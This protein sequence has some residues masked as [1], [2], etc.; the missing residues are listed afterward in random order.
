MFK[1]W[2]K[3]EKDL[4]AIENLI[5]KHKRCL[6]VG[7]VG[8]GKTFIS[9]QYAINNP[10]KRFTFIVPNSKT[11]DFFDDF[12]AISNLGEIKKSKV[13]KRVNV[14]NYWEKI[15]PY[16]TKVAI[17]KNKVFKC[18]VDF[19]TL[20]TAKGILKGV[21]RSFEKKAFKIPK[22][23]GITIKKVITTE[24]TGEV[25]REKNTL[26]GKN[27]E[28][29]CNIIDTTRD[30]QWLAHSHIN[31]IT[32]T[33]YTNLPLKLL[34]GRNLVV[35]ETHIIFNNNK[36]SYQI[37]DWDTLLCMTATV[38]SNHL[39]NL[40]KM[41]DVFQITNTRTRQSYIDKYYN[42]YKIKGLN[43]KHDI[44]I[45]TDLKVPASKVIA[46]IEPYMYTRLG[47]A[48]EKW[49]ETI[50]TNKYKLSQ[51]TIA[52]INNIVNAG[53]QY[54]TEDGKPDFRKELYTIR[55]EN[56]I[57]EI[58]T[59][60]WFLVVNSKITETMMI[61]QLLSGVIEIS[62][63]DGEQ[64]K[65]VIID[66]SRYVK[67]LEL[68][69][70]E[71]HKK[72]VIFYTYTREYKLIKYMIE[73]MLPKSEIYSINGATKDYLEN[74]GEAESHYTLAQYTSASQGINGLQELYNSM[75]FFSLPLSSRH[76]TQA[77]G[78][79]KR[80]GQVSDKVF[81][82]IIIADHT[83]DA[84]NETRIDKGQQ[85]QKMFYKGD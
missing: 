67:L 4:S 60:D 61:N 73:K 3:Q 77:K 82:D 41:F 29:L 34:S 5:K 32:P 59:P 37:K 74:K 52:I 22:Q 13:Q 17:Y 69:R 36:V 72:A 48:D 43:L 23:E 58:D 68:L 80:P 50:T 76:I 10:D 46:E 2:E 85:L 42:S 27:N 64:S 1:L 24:S 31:I 20:L 28:V 14:P 84:K 83:N 40:Y 44:V 39:Q 12:I 15:V 33:M 11:K 51:D 54:F 45:Q 53:V 75:I 63:I 9:L 55:D 56:E 62:H 21:R 38:M 78:R 18:I 8:V 66:K 19:D 65:G 25:R 49:K 35:D 16:G 30:T 79:I 70:G 7:S 26:F 6:F 71:K 57:D 47:N 81:Y